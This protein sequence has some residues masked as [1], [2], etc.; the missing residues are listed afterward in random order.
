M[1]KIVPCHRLPERS[2]FYKGKQ[3]PV[4]ARC[5]GVFLGRL[6]A[7]ALYWFLKPVWWVVVLCALVM[8]VDWFIQHIELLESTN[9]RRLITGILGGYAV[10]SVEI[11]VVV[12]VIRFIWQRYFIK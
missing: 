1:I 9:V 2:F 11:H 5:T 10:L 8:F 4:C 6:L 7:L 12:V 3:F